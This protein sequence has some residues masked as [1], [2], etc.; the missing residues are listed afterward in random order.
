[1]ARAEEG[2]EAG[3]VLGDQLLEVQRLV[4]VHA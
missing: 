4:L 1:V 3:E 2:E